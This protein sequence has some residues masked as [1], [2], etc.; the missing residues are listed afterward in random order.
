MTGTAARSDAEIHKHVL[1]ELKWD[2]RVD[3]TEIG[4]AVND[5]IVTL[6]GTVSSHGK[7][8]AAQEAAHRVAGVLDVANDIRILIPD[9]S[10]RT[11]TDIAH[12]VRQALLWDV[13]IPGDQITSTVTNGW[14][15]LE[16]VVSRWSYRQYAEHAM[17]NLEG[18]RG[19]TNRIKISTSQV[20]AQTIQRTIQEAL[21]RRAGREADRIQVLV[22]DGSVSLIGTVHSALEK[23]AILGAVGHAPGVVVVEDHL[24]IAPEASYPF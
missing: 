23:T 8:M 10:V 11:D 4:V 9:R 24:H 21:E 12:A 6:T 16:G 13:L 20:N 2:S 22:K 18:V 15:T 7:K 14:V 17:R 19:I 3:E 5:S 1:E